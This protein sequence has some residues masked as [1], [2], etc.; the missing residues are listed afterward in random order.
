MDIQHANAANQAAQQ[1]YQ[2]AQSS[3][4]REV[5]RSED[6]NRAQRNIAQDGAGSRGADSVEISREA[7]E[8]AQKNE[9]EQRAQAEAE[10]GPSQDQPGP[11]RDI[12]K[13]V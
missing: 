1:V 7:Q 3:G 5:E 11:E 9:T 12:S 10:G 6:T 13:V 4:A 8:L 2:S